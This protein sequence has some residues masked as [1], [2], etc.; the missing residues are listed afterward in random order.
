MN[1]IQKLYNKYRPAGHKSA[2]PT[3]PNAKSYAEITKQKNDKGK[4]K[5]IPEGEPSKSL[6]ES[7][8]A[9]KESQSSLTGIEKKL[10]LV[11]DKLAGMQKVIN[12]LAS[13]ILQLEQWQKTLLPNNDTNKN[14]PI[15]P[16]T[17]TPS[18]SKTVNK[19]V[20]VTVSSESDVP[21]GNTIVNQPSPSVNQLIKE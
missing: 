3:G 5:E 14:V 4:A 10:D 9:P 21:K 1:S 18:T 6:K 16:V 19:R 8:H 2:K 13:R 15:Q 11:L 20:R 17:P 7:V 12:N